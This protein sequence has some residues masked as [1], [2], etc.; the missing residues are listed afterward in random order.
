MIGPRSYTVVSGNRTYPRNV[1][2]LR[3]VPHAANLLAS[4]EQPRDTNKEQQPIQRAT[5]LGNS[6]E[7]TP[8]PVNPKTTVVPMASSPT[9]TRSGRTVRPPVR[10]QDYTS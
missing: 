8:G 9:L 4:S 10:F 6:G 2:Q 1:R 3:L 7:A 5:P